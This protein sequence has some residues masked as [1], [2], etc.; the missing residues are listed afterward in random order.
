VLGALRQRLPV[1]AAGCGDEEQ[2][3][4]IVGR[5]IPQVLLLPANALNADHLAALLDRLVARGY[6][7]VD[8]A[9]ALADPAYAAADRYTGPG[10]ITWLHRW[11]ITRGVEP[12]VLRSEPPPPEWVQLLARIRE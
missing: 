5:E 8:L 6:R 11:A 9:T 12:A 4:A 3:T 7:L 2:S 1:I 10:G